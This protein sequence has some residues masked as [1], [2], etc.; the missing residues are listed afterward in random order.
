MPSRRLRRKRQFVTERKLMELRKKIAVSEQMEEETLFKVTMEKI[1]VLELQV[2]ILK[3][4]L[5]IYGD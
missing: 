5:E 2:D 1:L 4:L 3:S